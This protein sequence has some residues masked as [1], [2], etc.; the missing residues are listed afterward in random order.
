MGVEFELK[1]AAQLQQQEGV[2]REFPGNWQTFSME[3]TYYDTPEGALSQRRYTLRLR[4]ENHESICTLKTPLPE[5][6]RGE[7]EC[8]CGSMEAAI[9]E[10]CKLMGSDHLLALTAAGVQPVCGA[11]FTRRA[12]MLALG[13]CTVEIALDRGVLTGGGKE[14]PLCEIEVELK[15]G[16]AEAAV[17]FARNL[18]EHFGLLPE[19]RSKFQ[20]A[21]ALAEEA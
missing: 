17:E 20:R 13:S 19:P 10:L 5:G 2:F 14:L 9:P 18:A 6:S 1:Y 12:R 8:R 16:A 21:R 3:T 7:W 4:R 11:K 15:E